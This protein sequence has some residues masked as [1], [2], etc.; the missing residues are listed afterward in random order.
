MSVQTCVLY[1]YGSIVFSMEQSAGDTFEVDGME[2]TLK[3]GSK[4]ELRCIDD[5]GEEQIIDV[6]EV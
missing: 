2:C 3:D 4:S 1:S 6:E 5:E